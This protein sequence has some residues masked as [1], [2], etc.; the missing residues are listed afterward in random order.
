MEKAE[1]QVWLKDTTGFDFDDIPQELIPVFQSLQDKIFHSERKVKALLR[2]KQLFTLLVNGTVDMF[3]MFSAKDY[4]VEYVSPNIEYLLG[5][6]RDDIWNNVWSIYDTAVDEVHKP[7]MEELMQIPLGGSVQSLNEHMNQRTGERRWYRKTIYH[8]FLNHD[9]KFILVISDRTTEMEM[10]KQL[11]LSIELTKSANEAKSSFLAN[12]SHDIRTPMNAIVGFSGLLKHDAE[13]PAKVRDYARKI[14]S[15]SHHLLNL[16]NDILDMSKIESGKATLH[17]EEFN[18]SDLLEDI[19]IVVNPQ[20]KAKKQSF[21]V[22]TQGVVTD[23]VMGDK[24]RINQI[25]L[26]LLSNSVKYTPDGGAIQLV[27]TQE[28]Q[29]DGKYANL[30]FQVIDNGMGM[31]PE[32]LEVIFDAFTREETAAVRGIQGT[33]L[34]MAITKNLVELMGGTISVASEQGKGTEFTVNMKLQATAVDTDREFWKDNDIHK[35]LVVDNDQEICEDIKKVMSETGVVVAHSNSGEEAIRFIKGADRVK[36]QY[37][38]VLLDRNM[39]VMGGVDIA[40]HISESLGEAAPAMV[41]SAYDWSDIE[42]EALN[43][44]ICGFIP[45]PF[46]ISNFRSAILQLR[47]KEP[48]EQVDSHISISGMRILAAEDNELNAEI[49]KELLDLE[50]ASCDLAENGE[51]AVNMFKNSEPGY[52]DIILMD[53]QMPVMDG[54]AATKVIRKCGHEDAA[55][56]P[57]AAMTANA[58]EED[59]RLALNA[60]MD[61]HIAKPVDMNLL[62]ETIIGVLPGKEI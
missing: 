6:V 49:L 36:Q 45:K 7:D 53:V 33:G 34:G 52:Y 21:R 24:T 32:Y 29:V 62:K 26:N 31:S 60:G 5:M 20:A 44:G 41:L 15:S 23:R 55:R 50:G 22:K 8:F 51:E 39:P 58:F 61:A 57:I 27:L 19:S 40:Q 28:G 16:I 54:Y 1:L 47:D 43:A 25:L 13:N 12:M 46:F 2:Q 17:I 4:R 30:R 56:I 3:V 48:E 14:S 18:L 42:E 9:H 10:Q 37:D 59:A 35:V 11:E 38:L